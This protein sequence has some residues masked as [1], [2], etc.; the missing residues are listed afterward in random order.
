MD[1]EKYIFDYNKWAII[2][3]IN[4]TVQAYSNYETSRTKKIAIKIYTSYLQPELKLVKYLYLI[5]S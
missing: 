5:N 1:L 2:S 4:S 3:C